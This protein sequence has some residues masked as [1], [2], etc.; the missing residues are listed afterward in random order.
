VNDRVSDALP[1]DGLNDNAQHYKRDFWSKENLKFGRPWYRLEKSARIISRLAGGKECSLL[2][3]GCGPAAL[4][5][6]LPPNIRYHGI[7]IAIQEPAPNLLEADLL[8]SHIRFGDKHFDIIIAQGVFEYMSGLQSRKFA[9]IA[10]LLNKNGAFIVS[11]A[12]FGHRKKNIYEA[13]SNVQPISDFRE[14]LASYFNI[15]RSFPG[16]HNWAHT[17]PNRK[18]VKVI[19]M[20]TNVNIPFVSP[21][22]AVE[23]FFICSP[24]NLNA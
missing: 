18:F 7:D 19:N 14:D 12:N 16:S 8:E 11:Y 3:I 24:R 5:R 10:Q 21:G 4:M 23:Y 1:R 20:Y 22:L 9:E 13:F 2:D 17:Q 15:D 6:L